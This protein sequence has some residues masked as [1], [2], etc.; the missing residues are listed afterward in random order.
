MSGR[1]MFLA[2]DYNSAINQFNDVDVQIVGQDLETEK[3]M[4]NKG[5]NFYGQGFRES[6]DSN[7]YV[8]SN[9]G[10]FYNGLRIAIANGDVEHNA[11]EFYFFDRNEPGFQR[12][13]LSRNGRI[14]SAP[15]GFFDGWENSIMDLLSVTPR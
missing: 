10:C 13:H 11:V 6:H 4:I 5:R 3:E 8:F 1:I 2:G 12:A 14:L 9:N 15:I 7:I